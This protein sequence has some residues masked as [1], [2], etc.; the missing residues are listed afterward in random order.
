MPWFS[1]LRSRGKM[2]MSAIAYWLQAMDLL[3]A[4][5]WFITPQSRRVA[6]VQRSVA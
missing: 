4:S 2:A 5:C 6:S 3:P 1:Q